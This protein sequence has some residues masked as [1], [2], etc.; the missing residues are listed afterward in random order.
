MK[1]DRISIV[2][3]T[4]E[5]FESLMELFTNDKVR[6]YLGGPITQG[7]AIEKAKRITSEPGNLEWI[8]ITARN[9]VAG[10]IMVSK[11]HDSSDSEISYQFLP[12]Y[13]GQ[14]IAS[15]SLEIVLEHLFQHWGIKKVLAET[16][17]KNLHSINL[18]KR[19]GFQ[20]LRR[21]HRYEEDQILFGKYPQIN[22]AEISINQFD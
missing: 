15:E 12:E 20:E 10:L 19:L 11:H 14:G 3:P 18:L 7:K 13:W 22:Q 4:S 17:L 16:Q 9:A 21:L 6:E 5:H 8:V 1:T 2:K